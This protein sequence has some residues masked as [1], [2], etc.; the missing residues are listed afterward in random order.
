MKKVWVIILLVLIITVGLGYYQT[1][2]QQ[3]QYNLILISIDALRP[4]RMGVYGYQNKTTP[5]IDAWAK[6]AAVFSNAI[7]V[8]PFT[9]T[10]FTALFTG[11]H[12]TNLKGKKARLEFNTSNASLAEILKKQGYTT[13]GF[14]QNKLLFKGNSQLHL[15]FDQYTDYNEGK[16]IEVG[17]IDN[18]K[19]WIV[20]HSSKKMFLWVHIMPPHYPYVPYYPY[21]CAQSEKNCD[22]ARSTDLVVMKKE[23]EAVTGCNKES[24]T[25]HG[26]ND[27]Q[28]LLYD[29][30]VNYSDYL[31]GQILA[32]IKKSGLDKNSIIVL[33]GDHGEGFDHNYYYAH[34]ENVYQSTIRIPLIIAHPQ[35]TRQQK[36]SRL[37]QNVDLSSFFQ[38]ILNKKTNLNT[39][40]NTIK[41]DIAYSISYGTGKFA[42]ISSNGYKYIYSSDDT[43][44][45]N[46]QSEELYNLALDPQE[47][48]NIIESA[49]VQTKQLKNSLGE[50]I[51]GL[52]QQMSPAKKDD[53]GKAI[54]NLKNQL[55]TVQEDQN[56]TTLE[57]LKS[58]GY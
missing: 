24:L 5:N 7:S 57:D 23:V 47:Q 13:A 17:L 50:Y 56:K 42:A 6:Q 12:V 8:A 27:L 35:I 46:N 19:N 45:L 9:I 1:H 2:K 25:P 55:S 38:R 15:G 33:Y 48:N 39:E 34:A 36:I 4:D 30:E 40:V 14:V 10:S 37:I 43:C 54:K 11:K 29:S 16:K 44:L 41:R 21:I 3:K 52:K 31:F 20:G 18:I 28:N 22:E 32:Q 58:L 49:S 26:L 51:Q 53:L